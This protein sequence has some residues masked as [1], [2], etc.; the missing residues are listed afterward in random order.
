MRVYSGGRGSAASTSLRGPSLMAA[1]NV[2]INLVECGV[3]NTTATAFAVALMR[4]TT[5]GTRTGSLTEVPEDTDHTVLADV[6]TGHS[7]DAAV[8]GGPYVQ[9]SIGAAIGAGVIW[10]FGKSGLRVPA[11]TAN[12]FL[13][14]LPTGTGQIFDFYFV[15]EE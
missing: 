14:A 10:T 8:T 6:A 1:A 9:A 2:P 15:W 12:G 5:A 7:A 11:G 4:V 3:F 13:L